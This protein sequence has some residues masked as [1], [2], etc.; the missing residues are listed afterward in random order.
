[1]KS[2]SSG[3]GDEPL[4]AVEDVLAGRGVADGRRRAA[5]AAS[6]PAP[7]SVIA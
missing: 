6:E 1:M 4:L 2:V 7:S 5:C 3:P